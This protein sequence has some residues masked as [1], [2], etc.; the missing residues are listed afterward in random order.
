MKK[1]RKVC[2]I[3]ELAEQSLAL[4]TLLQ[5]RGSPL[6]VALELLRIIK[7]LSLER[8]RRHKTREVPKRKDV[9]DLEIKRAN[10]I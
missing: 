4:I 7:K 3:G 5:A 10:L 9:V 2:P 6:L 8:K 1:R